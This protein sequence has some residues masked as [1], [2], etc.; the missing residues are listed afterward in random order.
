MMRLAVSL[1]TVSATLAI[2]GLWLLGLGWMALL[3]AAFT[4]AVLVAVLRAPRDPDPGV[5]RLGGRMPAPD[6]RIPHEP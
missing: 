2:G 6:A 4:V 1:A 5:M 3:L